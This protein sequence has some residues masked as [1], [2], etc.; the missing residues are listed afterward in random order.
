MTAH[1]AGVGFGGVVHVQREKTTAAKAS[2]T[3]EREEAIA[4]E[5]SKPRTSAR[6]P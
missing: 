5:V 3:T 4:R 2:P 1:V 6:S